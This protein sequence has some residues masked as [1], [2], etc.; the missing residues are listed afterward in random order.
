MGDAVMTLPAL[1]A[2]RNA[3]K[4]SRISVL[5]KEAVLPL[6]ENDP[7]VD[8]LVKYAKTHEKLLGK[9]SL[10]SLLRAEKYDETILFQNAFDAALVT[11]LAGIKKRTGYDRDAR[12]LFLTK[13]IP[14]NKQTLKLHHVSYYLNLLRETGIVAPYMLP[15]IYLTLA[16]RLSARET[17][18]PLKRP[19]VGINPQAAY[20][21]AKCWS[22]DNYVSVINH[23][24]T[25]LNG[26]VVI[27]GTDT[28]NKLPIDSL[29]GIVTENTY[30]DLTGKTGLRQLC[31]LISECDAVITNDSGPMHI[32][33]ATATPLVAIFGS[34]SFELTGPPEIPKDCQHSFPY[35][36]LHK[37]LDCS[38]CFRRTCPHGHLKCMTSITPDEV[39]EALRDILCTNK[40]VFFD[41]DGTICEDAHYLNDF[42]DFKPFKGIDDLRKLKEKGYLLIGVTNQSGIAR[43]IVNETF[44]QEI[45]NLFIEKYSFDGFYYCKHVSADKCACRK[46]SPGMLYKA[47]TDFKIDLKNSFMVGD[48]DADINVGI[49]VGASPVYMESKKYLLTVPDI[50]RISSLAELLG[51]LCL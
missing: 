6:F 22:A 25:N 29:K 51:M 37:S 19:I 14:I 34:T 28:S 24:V 17:L 9:L 38:P 2:L 16:E 23:I 42:K 12:G 21:S 47:R 31:A 4:D 20:G 40:A 50:K 8:A 27:F 39:C 49:A 11:F 1:R 7:N 32:A 33:Y 44:V 13:R 15:W 18:Q 36:V 35:R 3:Y 43:G 45:N 10:S 41:R 26:S 46:P 30:L 48:K 5:A